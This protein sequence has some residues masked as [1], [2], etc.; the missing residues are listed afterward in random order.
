MSNLTLN[1]KVKYKGKTYYV[2]ELAEILMLDLADTEGVIATINSLI[3]T[4]YAVPVVNQTKE[5]EILDKV[6]KESAFQAVVGMIED[7]EAQ[8]K[9]NK[10][11]QK[12]AESDLVS[13]KL[14]FNTTLEGQKFCQWLMEIGIPETSFE[15]NK[16]MLSGAIKLMLKEVT[17]N[18]S[19]KIINKYKAEHII[20][21]TVDI[22]DKAVTKTTD[23]VNYVASEVVAPVAKIAGTGVLN[24]GKG[25]F[26]TA[27][28]VGAGL[29]NSGAK[30]VVETKTAMATD[31]EL[32]KAQNQL[33]NAKNTVRRTVAE[34][35][36][37]SG[38]GSGIEFM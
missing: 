29:I 1:S 9:F 22:A 6:Q 35:M 7:E 11:E 25:L 10:R 3:R 26:H 2:S 27:F 14:N 17:T 24:L 38:G 28:K 4:G 15:L 32:L 20:A 33:I 34:K 13:F 8:V 30:A 37:K 21:Q 18:E 12:K 19:A 31:P 36:S 16:D 23:S 5:D